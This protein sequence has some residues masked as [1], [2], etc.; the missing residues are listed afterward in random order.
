MEWMPRCCEKNAAE[1]EVMF[2]DQQPNHPQQTQ[3][4]QG[5][6]SAEV[7]NRLVDAKTL[8]KRLWDDESRPSLRWLRQQQAERTIPYVK[9][10]AR[11]WF[12][13]VEVRRCLRERWTTGRRS[14]W[15]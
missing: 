15:K 13:P 5:S 11:V 3:K 14:G 12:D 4:A 9:L 7:E 2:N 8:L 1:L 6:H 10:G